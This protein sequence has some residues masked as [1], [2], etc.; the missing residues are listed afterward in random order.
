MNH[1]K[2]PLPVV[3]PLISWAWVFGGELKLAPIY[4]DNRVVQ[5]DQPVVLLGTA[6]PGEKI[7][8]DFAGGKSETVADAKGAFRIQPECTMP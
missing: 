8:A 7:A 2:K 6:G 4:T 3:I 5:R 1:L